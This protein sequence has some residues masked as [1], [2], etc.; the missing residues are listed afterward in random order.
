MLCDVIYHKPTKR[1]DYKDYLSIIYKDLVTN[2]KELM[3]ITEPEFTIYEVKDEYRTFKTARH[4]FGKD[5][6]IEH[7]IKYKNLHKEIADIIGD[8]GKRFLK[9]H[10]SYFDRRALFKYPY[11]LGADI[12]IET[13]YRVLWHEQLG[14]EL[15]KDITCQ[16]MDIE[17]NQ[18]H[19][20]GAGIPRHG[21]CPIDAVSLVDDC[22]NTVY[23]FLLKVPDNPQIEDF[24]LPENIKEFQKELHE[25]FDDVYGELTYNIYMYTSELELLQKLF[26][27][28]HS[29]KRD[30][31]LIW[32]MAFDIPYIISRIA[33]LGEDPAFIMCH[34]DFPVPNL[35]YKED[36]NT[37]EFANKR[38]YFDNSSY[39][40]YLD[41]LILY[42]ATRKS[43]GAV[44]KVNL[45]AVAQEELGDT[46][47]D[48]TDSGNFVDFSYQNYKKY[49]MYNIKDVLLQMG[50][51]RKTNDVMNY[52]YSVYNSFC[53]YKDG[54][55]QTVSLRGL[56]YKELLEE[57]NLIIGNNVNYDN[58]TESKDDD[59]DD[60]DDKFEGALNGDPL[61]NSHKGLLL[62]GKRSKFI[63][64][65]CIDLDFSAMYPNAIC[66]FNIFAESMIGKLIIL[67]CQDKVTYTEKDE[68]GNVDGGKEFVEDITSECPLFTGEKWFDLPSF[69]DLNTEVQ[70]RLNQKGVRNVA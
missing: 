37:F 27:L 6:C 64:G 69:E 53:G 54:L 44:K 48:Y 20:D 32:N 17:V 40:H 24:I 43:K 34:S 15:K 29:L 67:N 4:Y 55:K 46:K 60:D 45:G 47:L 70:R 38:D 3:K 16:Y 61:L 23:T 58:K 65:S 12:P 31:V 5:D 22:T 10:R 21:E 50:I 63:F 41:Q 18:K 19:W 26:T 51:N 62:F 30:F 13:Y 11:V 52:Y 1:T 66:A 8:P 14:N 2:Q 28:I 59:D 49:V 42:A 68:D 57:H 9:E 25:M 56:V 36:T 7:T 35:Y 39:S 33:E